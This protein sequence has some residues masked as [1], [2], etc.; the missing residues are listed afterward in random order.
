MGAIAVT[1]WSRRASVQRH[2]DDGGQEDLAALQ[3]PKP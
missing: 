2:L 3:A 1:A